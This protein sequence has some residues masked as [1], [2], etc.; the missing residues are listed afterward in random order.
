MDKNDFL[1]MGPWQDKPFSKD[2]GVIFSAPLLTY[3]L[4][5]DKANCHFF[6]PQAQ[7]VPALDSS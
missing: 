1:S 2:Y 4:E 5:Q 7:S 6:F 3:D